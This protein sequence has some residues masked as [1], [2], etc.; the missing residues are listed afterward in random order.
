[1]LRSVK[2]IVLKRYREKEA[3]E[4]IKFLSE[5][6]ENETIRIHGLRSSRN[7]SRL[8]SEPGCIAD[9]VFYRGNNRTTG[10]LKEGVLIE[11]F[12]EIKSSYKTSLLLAAFLEICA[13]VTGD[14]SGEEI[15]DLLS[16]GL[17]YIQDRI[18][19]G[20][21]AEKE[22]LI[23]L[24]IFFSI[25]LFSILG[26][27]G[28]TEHCSMCQNPF[29]K[30]VYWN[31]PSMD[32]LCHRCDHRASAEDF[33][34]LSAVRTALT[35][36]FEIFAGQFLTEKQNSGMA[37]PFLKNIKICLTGIKQNLMACEEFFK[38]NGI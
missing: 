32:F 26:M 13:S 24:F 16:R 7:R 2:G 8:L 33:I 12:D 1:M 28:D 9:L 34:F 3:D 17:F 31:L 36:K 21:A 14:E 27:S 20:Q 25:R 18:K 22:Y 30:S 38:Q 19:S 4:V 5:N 37:M 15:Y 10:S 29:Q 35:H 6:G 11:R 23:L